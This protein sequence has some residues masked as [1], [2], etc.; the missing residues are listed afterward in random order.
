M[1]IFPLA[2]FLAL[3]YNFWN[4]NPKPKKESSGE[5][6][7]VPYFIRIR[8]IIAPQKGSTGF[9]ISAVTRMILYWNQTRPGIGT[10]DQ[11]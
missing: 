6:S 3:F 9:K 8:P 10:I 1:R 7:E 5:M 2:L 11:N 4:N